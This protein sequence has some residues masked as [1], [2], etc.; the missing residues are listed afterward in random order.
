MVK[1]QILNMGL[2]DNRHEI[3]AEQVKD[4]FIFDRALTPDE[5]TNPCHLEDMV[6]S[7]LKA[8]A[9]K[10]AETV[11]LRLTVTGLTVA[12]I[13]VVNTCI[14]QDIDLVLLHFDR[15]SGKYF[16]QNVITNMW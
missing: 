3:P 9:N 15:A 16:E 14:K 7:K 11:E 13:A 1:K 5:M 4:G 2:V 10:D 8:V 12:T 6:G